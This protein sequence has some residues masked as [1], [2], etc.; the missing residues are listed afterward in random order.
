[1]TVGAVIEDICR[2]KGINQ[3]ELGQIGCIS[4]KTVSAIKLGRRS[5]AKDV[6][7]RWAEQLDHPRVYMEMVKESSG[8]AYGTT[9]LD[10]D[11][12]DLHRTTVFLKA[13]EELKEA[14]EAL[15]ATESIVVH[16]PAM[17]SEEQKDEIKE[18][19]LQCIDARVA[20]DMLLAVKSESYGFSIREL[21]KEHQRK[22][23]QRGYIK[24]V[25][26]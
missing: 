24:K 20:I 7:S 21:F 6:L 14:I 10:G 16:N 25:R 9:W 13:G 15:A 4:P 8:G 23:E 2:S 22:L 12:V 19:L 26:R 5:V 3:I 1:M 18:A 17:T 11:C